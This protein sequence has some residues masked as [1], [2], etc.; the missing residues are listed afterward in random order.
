MT[1][2]LLPSSI[3]LIPLQ[4]PRL[5]YPHLP[6]SIPL[7]STQLGLVL[8]AV[9][10]NLGGKGGNGERRVVGVV[11]VVDGDRRVGRWACAARIRGV[12]KSDE[13]DIYLLL[14]EG[15]CRIRLPRSLPPILSLLPNIPPPTSPFSLPL[16][17]LLAPTTDL[18]P[19][20]TKLLPPTLHPRLSSIPQGLLADLLVTVLGVEW[21]TRVELLGLPDTETR[22]QRVKE[23]LIEIMVARG[24]TPPSDQESTSEQ[25][26]TKTLDRAN[27]TALIPRQRPPHLISARS[28]PSP[29]ALA[30]IPDDLRPM[31]AVLQAR[32]L[33]LSSSAKQTVMREL[34]RLTKIPPQSAEYGVSKTYIEWLLALPWNKVTETPHELDLARARKML[35]EEHEGLEGVKKRVIEYLAVYSTTAQKSDDLDPEVEKNLLA[36]VPASER[37]GL[38]PEDRSVEREENGESDDGPPDDVFRDKGPILLLLGP[39]GV[40][41]TS[42]AKSLATSLG[43]KFHRISLGGVRDEAEIRGHRRTYV[44]ALPGLLV[45]AMRK[46]GVANPLILLDELDKVGHS[47]FHGDPS[48]ALLEA[49]DPAQ[50]WNFHDH[51]LGDVPI[52]L[53]QVLFI[54]TANSTENMS[55]PLLDRCEVIN[56]SGYITPEK[57]RIARRFLLP[58]QIRESGLNDSQVQVGDDVLE[59]V[60]T[61]Y[62]REAG[63]RTLE[64]QLGKLCRTKAVEFSA[65]REKK[66]GEDAV[67][68][69]YEPLIDVGDVE[70][71][72]GI[73]KFTQDRPE[74]PVRPGVVNGLSYNGSGNG[75]V[76]LIETL[77]VPGGH[78]KLVT[79][80][81]LGD[82]FRESI[83]ICLTWVKSRSLNLGITSSPTEHP[84]KDVDVHYH[85]P[86]GAVPK[87]GP[88]AGI[89]TV[90][91]FVSLLTGREVDSGLAVTGEMSLRG[92]VLRIGGVK[93]KVIGAHRAGIIKIILPSANRGDV[94][95]DVPE[96]V[97][98]DITFVFVDNIEQA[99]EEVWGPNIWANQ[100]KDT[101]GGK[102]DSKRKK[103]TKVEARL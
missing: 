36:L 65:S 77:L 37:E 6:A 71:V 75:G 24:I 47:S 27:S 103:S 32:E 79:T 49:L 33:T 8:D 55:W 28:T 92:A 15:L 83:E 62:T 80:G 59:K 91:A 98:R 10:K 4:K 70:K 93:E 66:D 3:P 41:K 48:A 68:A 89:A 85:I 97:K 23:L 78:G 19:Y 12:G 94:K 40:G 20:A 101:N 64:R 38:I 82:V 67:T 42:I 2:P 88:S 56:C 25:E 44:G 63:V 17:P 73:P 22:C 34:T 53:S 26:K 9:S 1:T 51:Y 102:D 21:E 30:S 57:L 43:R 87:D 29:K 11:P 14:V 60:I 96:Q 31:Y 5:L 45:Q 72:L 100:T 35:D 16:T 7:S 13:P 99:I 50:N 39:P 61:E 90:L 95:E 18:L 74:G 58:K 46:V 69:V 76:L 52:D 54:A 86:E 81:R 84:L